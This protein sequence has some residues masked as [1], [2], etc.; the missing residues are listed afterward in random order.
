MSYICISEIETRPISE[1]KKNRKTTIQ[2]YLYF[3]FGFF[4]LKNEF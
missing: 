2:Y 3:C 1:N 4:C